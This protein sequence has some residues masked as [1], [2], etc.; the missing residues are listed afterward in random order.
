LAAIPSSPVVA[1]VQTISAVPLSVLTSVPAS[2]PGGEPPFDP[3]WVDPQAKISPMGMMLLTGF[4]V[5]VLSDSARAQATHVPACNA[6]LNIAI[7]A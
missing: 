6:R 3:L 4:N 5:G 7:A 1:P 2:V